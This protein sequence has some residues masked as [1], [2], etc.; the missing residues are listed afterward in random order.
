MHNTE[1]KKETYNNNLVPGTSK[2]RWENMKMSHL[3]D[4]GTLV[5]G[6]GGKLTSS[7]TDPGESRKV[8]GGGG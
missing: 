6:G 2:K 5:Q 1:S 8:R 7:G 4:I 3:G